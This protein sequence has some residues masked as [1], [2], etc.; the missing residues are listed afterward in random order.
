MGRPKAERRQLSEQEQDQVF[1]LIE[2]HSLLAEGVAFHCWHEY[3]L[4]DN[5]VF[6][7]ILDVAY[8]G[9]Y[10]GATDYVVQELERSMG[11]ERA[12]L[13]RA[14]AHDII[15]FARKEGRKRNISL[16]ERAK[17]ILVNEDED[18][19][20]EE[21]E[22]SHLEGA[23]SRE[24]VP[25]LDRLKAFARTLTGQARAACE[26]MLQGL[27]EGHP[28]T[29]T[30]IAKATGTSERRLR[31]LRHLTKDEFLAWYQQEVR[32]DAA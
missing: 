17:R 31:R 18:E 29:H 5:F 4:Y 21:A 10:D 16:E 32:K 2:A 25:V 6:D 9:L 24:Y 14:I 30:E 23:E 15:D 1:D 3:K 8:Q 26:E 27:Q 19:G 7:A 28:R 12:Y 22:F 20:E 11:R 13:K